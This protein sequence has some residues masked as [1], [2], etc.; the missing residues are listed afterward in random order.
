VPVC[1]ITIQSLQERKDVHTISKVYAVPLKTGL[2]AWQN[3]FRTFD[4]AHKN[5]LIHMDLIS[6]IFYNSVHLVY[7]KLNKTKSFLDFAMQADQF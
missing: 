3:Q 2:I 7:Q 1:D 5:V 4:N 6:N